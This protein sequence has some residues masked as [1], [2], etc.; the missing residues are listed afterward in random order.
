MDAMKAR[1]AIAVTFAL[2]FTLVPTALAGTAEQPE[3][4]DPASDQTVVRGPLVLPP[5]EDAFDDVDIV[6]AWAGPE[7]DGAVLISV[8]T[9][10]EGTDATATVLE[11]SVASGPTS[12]YSSTAN[13]TRYTVYVNGTAAEG[14]AGV[15]AA[16]NGAVLELEVPLASIGAVGGDLLDGL[17]VSRSRADAGDLPDPATQ[18]DQSATDTAPDSGAGSPYAFA[19]PPIQAGVLLTLQGASV[20]EGGTTSQFGTDPVSVQDGDA[21]VVY[22]VSVQNTGTDL[23]TVRLSAP[24]PS[25]AARVTLSDTVLEL[26][27]GAGETVTLTVQL[28]DA[29]GGDL[30]FTLTGGSDRGATSSLALSLAVGIPAPPAPDVREPTPKGLDFLTPWVEKAGFDGPFGDYAELVLLALLVLLAVLLVFLLLMLGRRPWVKVK[31]H[32]RRATAAPGESLEFKVEV[33]NPKG[34]ER[35]AKARLRE[36]GDGWKAGILL[37]QGDEPLRPLVRTDQDLDLTLPSRR[38]P[39]SALEGT[40]R[41]VVP[42][43][44]APKEHREI[45][46]DVVPLDARGGEHPAHAG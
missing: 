15:T 42:A 17:V 14:V 7:A 26:A 20:T 43:G 22:Q 27:P 24:S 18:D 19:R 44:A 6:A 2:A 39:A 36:A 25:A 10:A 30:A 33:R 4:S 11:F 16:Q 32:P 5:N 8:A 38:D 21:R 37:R 46:L 3:V 45:G 12:L 23:D 29:P 34:K 31:I 40:M 1:L 35:H 13:G 9:T 28:T 41:V